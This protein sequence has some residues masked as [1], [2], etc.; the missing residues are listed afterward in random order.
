MICVYMINEDHVEF[1]FVE[2]VV[3]IKLKGGK[4]TKKRLSMAELLAKAIL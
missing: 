1:D 4:M 2:R 3:D